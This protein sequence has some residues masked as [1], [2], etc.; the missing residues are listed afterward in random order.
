MQCKQ[1]GR[2]KRMKR[3]YTMCNVINQD[4]VEVQAIGNN[5]HR[6][7]NE[8][9]AIGC[10][11]FKN[12]LPDLKYEEGVIFVEA[13]IESEPFE[14]YTHEAWIYG[15]PTNARISSLKAHWSQRKRKDGQRNFLACGDWWLNVWC[16]KEF[17]PERIDVIKVF[18]KVSRTE[19]QCESDFVH[20]S[21]NP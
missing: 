1:I 11:F 8:V 3:I 6:T 10:T 13:Q 2:V 17:F 5:L 19:E 20:S 7:E 16:M 9:T 18:I 14:G 12:L 4:G 21:D 15:A